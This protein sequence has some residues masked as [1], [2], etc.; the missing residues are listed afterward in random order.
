MA[1]W[2]VTLAVTDHWALSRWLAPEISVS[3]G[4]CLI[5]LVKMVEDQLSFVGNAGKRQ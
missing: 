3:V 5:S 1:Y 2:K 4:I